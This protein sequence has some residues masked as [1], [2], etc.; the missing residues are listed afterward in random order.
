M[1]TKPVG[2]EGWALPVGLGRRNH[3][4]VAGKTLCHP[5]RLGVRYG[6]PTFRPKPN[7]TNTCGVDQCPKCFKLRQT[8]LKKPVVE[9]PWEVKIERLPDDSL[10]LDT[11]TGKIEE[12]GKAQPKQEHRRVSFR[13]SNSRGRWTTFVLVGQYFPDHQELVEKYLE[14]EK[15]RREER[16]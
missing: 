11:K 8:Q 16:L 1:T 4:Y 6:Q 7:N 5:K 12:I 10:L 14:A 2:T 15:K 9:A 13:R 3:F